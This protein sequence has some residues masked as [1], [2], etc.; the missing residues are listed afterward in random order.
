MKDLK[1]NNHH[2]IACFPMINYTRFMIITATLHTHNLPSQSL[3][4]ILFI[5]FLQHTWKNWQFLSVWNWSFMVSVSGNG[6]KYKGKLVLGL[7]TRPPLPKTESDYQLVCNYTHAFRPIALSDLV[8]TVREKC[9]TIVRGKQTTKH[10]QNNDS[11]ILLFFNTRH[12]YSY[13]IV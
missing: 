12:G 5:C 2:F 8:N 11:P 3:F 10:Y 6:S 7:M 4:S 1:K 9:L 13:R